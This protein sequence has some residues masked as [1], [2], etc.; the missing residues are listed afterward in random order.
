[1]ITTTG[2]ARYQ[3]AIPL[4][5]KIPGTV[6]EATGAGSS[7]D[8]AKKYTR[9]VVMDGGSYVPM[10]KYISNMRKTAEQLVSMWL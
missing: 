8:H 10:R 4:M 3:P 6:S 5:C 9:M 7:S 2:E 1:M